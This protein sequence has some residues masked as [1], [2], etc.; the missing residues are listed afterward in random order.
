MTKPADF[1]DPMELVG[2]QVLGGDLRAMAECLVEEYLLLG[3]DERQLMLLFT[4][5]C[6][7]A[8]HRIYRDKGE[9][10]VRSLIQ[11]VRDKWTRNSSCREP[12]DA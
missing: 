1:E 6:F 3:W 5:P 11:E 9:A 4:R 12:F 7:R 10:Y 8:T 2:V